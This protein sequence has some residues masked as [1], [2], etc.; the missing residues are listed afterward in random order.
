MFV[1]PAT[2]PDIGYTIQPPTAVTDAEGN[3]VPVG[4]LTYEIASDNP[5]AVAVTPSAGDPLAGTVT[6]GAPNADG[7]PA[8]AAVTVLVKASDGS[9]LGSYGAQFTVPAGPA[10]AIVG[11]G[12]TFDGIV[13]Q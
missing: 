12:I 13:E 3:A 4:A 10:T 6:F 5:G 11:G 9:L 8:L 7:S 2:N 1:V